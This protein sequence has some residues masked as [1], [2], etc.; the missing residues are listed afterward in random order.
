MTTGCSRQWSASAGSVSRAE[1]SLWGSIGARV[2]RRGL[3]P[4]LSLTRVRRLGTRFLLPPW[5][6]GAALVHQPWCWWTSGEP[7]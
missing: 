6:S 1:L 4:F 3:V 2:R 7:S 5:S